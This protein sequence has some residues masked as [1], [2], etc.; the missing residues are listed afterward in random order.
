MNS[1]NALQAGNDLYIMRQF[2]GAQQKMALRQALRGE[3]GDYFKDM[4]RKLVARISEMPETYG[5]DGLGDRAIAY[6]HYFN[7]GM[8]W[9]I[10][11]RDSDPDGEGQ[12]QA[13][14]VA[15]L[16]YGDELGYISIAE[17]VENG[18]E[19]DLYFKPRA[20]SEIKRRCQSSIA[21]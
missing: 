21:A 20:L 4:L 10:T 14:G 13:F 1:A 18:V 6:L 3:E 15:N 7:A 16:G 17:L 12:V 2:I 9:Y 8:D 5:Q 19:I 11:E